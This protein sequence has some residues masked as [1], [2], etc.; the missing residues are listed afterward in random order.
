MRGGL[1]AVVAWALL[2]MGAD[3][4]AAFDTGPHGDQ[5]VDA[6]RAEGFG[7]DA[8]DVSRVNNWFVDFY[9][10]AGDVPY[11]D[12]SPLW[13]TVIGGALG[14]REHWPK[15]LR[16]AASAS[17]MDSS[18]R[19]TLDG[20]QVSLNEPR[21]MELEWDRLRFATYRL[22]QKAKRDRSPLELLTA[23]GTS[24]HPLQD[25]YSHTNWPETPTNV[26]GPG[27]QGRGQGSVPTWFD[28]PAEVRNPAPVYSGG[29]AGAPRVHGQWRESQLKTV[30]KD[31]PGRPRY[32]EAYM[33]AY[34]AT[35]QWL[36][37]I[38]SWLGDARLWSQA[39]RYASHL[40]DLDHDDY[41]ATMISTYTGHL[42][43]EGGPCRP[44]CDVS[45]GWGGS[46]IALR[47]AVK[48]YFESGRSGHFTTR[49]TVF[50]K[51]FEKLMPDLGIR[52]P[53]G[54]R[55][56]QVPVASSRPIQA[57]TRFVR[58][59]VRR[60]RGID[61]GDIGPDD[62]DL[63]ARGAI[64]GQ[65]FVSPVI[66][67]H[68]SFSFPAPYYP[69]TFVKAVPRG[70]VRPEPIE[71]IQ[72]RIRTSSARYAGTDDNV[73]LRI[74][75]EHRFR[76]DKGLYDDFERGDNDLY[77]V[78]IDAAT[79][80]GLD[81]GDLQRVQ[82]EKSRDGIAGGW[83]LRGVT[84]VVNRR[85]V[86]R[87][88][89]I[90]RWLEDDHRTWRAPDFRPDV[91][92]GTK[93]PVWLDLREDDL[94]IYGSDDQGDI[95]PYDARDAVA[96]GYAPGSPRVEADTRGGHRLGGRLGHGGDL[97]SVRYWI[98][99]WDPTLPPGPVIK[100]PPPPAPK[101]DLIVSD[102]TPTTFTIRNQ[103]AG[104]AGASTALLG[105]MLSYPIGAL[106]PGGTQT[107][108]FAESCGGGTVTVRADK[109]GVVDET[110]ETN[111]EDSKLFIC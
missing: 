65:R 85:T 55:L 106:A 33:T 30:A 20:Q 32:M 94:R 4:A 2:A 28:L 95:N 60:M 81:L 86:Y 70:A 3:S 15:R 44:R 101:P 47:S 80:K 19:V 73:Y 37:A 77:S 64:A 57:A 56:D 8:A 36:R 26:D 79:R 16:D 7:P 82:I 61:L 90:E 45:S 69:F 6:M 25:F 97:A 48:R 87:R 99:T 40:R 49:K 31:W 91:R 9:S 35:R 18:V 83:K 27:W 88:D 46:L 53:L 96:V 43:G 100:P 76:L 103:G 39:Q 74:G 66:Q 10:N 54:V 62:A 50:R 75:R 11:S 111:N 34:F 105:T 59:Q 72:V 102:I 22:V 93:V 109:D 12:S 104:A 51:T 98:D 58:L 14:D 92:P 71:S 108:K 1:A 23:I 67:A 24:L 29:S 110:D 13:K 63:Y 42:Y 21:A 89:G 78:P 38:R 41:G 17:H 52:Q 5:T 84:L 68:D 107:V